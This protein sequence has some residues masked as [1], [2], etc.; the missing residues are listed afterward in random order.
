MEETIEAHDVDAEA[1]I[2]FPTFA[3]RLKTPQ[4][5]PPSPAAESPNDMIKFEPTP[6]QTA[7]AITTT[8]F[9][10]PVKHFTHLL[11][12]NTS[13]SLLSVPDTPAFET[14]DPTEGTEIWQ[15]QIGGF[16]SAVRKNEK[17]KT[18]LF[19]WDFDSFPQIIDMFSKTA[20]ITEEQRRRAATITKL[21]FVGSVYN[22]KLLIKFPPP[23]KIVGTIGLNSEIKLGKS[24]SGRKQ[25]VS[26]VAS[27]KHDA[28]DTESELSFRSSDSVKV[29]SNISGYFES[30]LF[31]VTVE[32]TN[33]FRPPGPLQIDFEAAMVLK[34][35]D[36]VYRGKIQTVED[37]G[38]GIICDV[39]DTI[40]VSNVITSEAA[41]RTLLFDPPT[42]IPGMSEFVNTVQSILSS[43]IYLDAKSHEEHT[44]TASSNKIP[45][46]QTLSLPLY[47]PP[48]A[49]VHYVSSAPINLL[50]ELLSFADQYK[51]PHGSSWHT[52]KF[53]VLDG[54]MFEYFFGS[55]TTYKYETIS[56]V[57]DRFE[58]KSFVLIGDS[59][60][61]DPEIFASLAKKFGF[62]WPDDG[63]EEDTEFKGGK[64]LH[65]FIRKVKDS[66]GKAGTTIAK[67]NGEE[68]FANAFAGL[69]KKLWTTFSDPKEILECP[70]GVLLSSVLSKLAKF[71]FAT[72]E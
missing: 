58:T 60:Q 67:I 68:R 59:G 33:T 9:S 40:R 28:S 61:D 26:S 66:T 11:K 34:K 47:I 55:P 46:K 2:F 30:P 50:P 31:A 52:K 1:V 16:V 57:L 35:G 62:V 21:F 37:G 10:R 15:V 23:A 7:G 42:E 20:N 6:T 22:Q 44:N 3:T 13:S 24:G 18:G 14:F 69:P 65:I 49:S 48:P 32:E 38:F 27:L 29:K 64:I 71:N 4:Q 25:T 56:M 53:S 70:E 63:D 51:F 41:L 12:M 54:S 45:S 8:I 17:K 36:E 43:R 19:D 72:R 5:P 39:E